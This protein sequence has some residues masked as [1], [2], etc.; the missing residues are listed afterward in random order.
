MIEIKNID[1]SR[2]AGEQFNFEEDTE[3]SIFVEDGSFWVKAESLKPDDNNY[4]AAIAFDLNK[5]FIEALKAF[6][7]F[8]ERTY[9][10]T[11]YD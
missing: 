8:I 3:N 11:D 2:I 4:C 7:T 10:D 1:Y 5:E 6:I 9:K